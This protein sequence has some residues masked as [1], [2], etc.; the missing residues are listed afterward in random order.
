MKTCILLYDKVNLLS[1]ASVYELLNETKIPFKILALHG[2][3]YD[4]K[5]YK[6]LANEAGE[7]LLSYEQIIIPDGLGALNLRHDDIFISWIKSSKNA[8]R[9]IALNLGNL[10]FGSAGFL[11]DKKACFKAGYFHAAKDY[12]EPCEDDFYIDD[13]IFSFRGNKKSLKELNKI[14]VS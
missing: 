2:E 14:L 7:S 12:C 8:K 13:D 9:K 1:F 6:L 4:E 11:K 3:T 10:L 5:G